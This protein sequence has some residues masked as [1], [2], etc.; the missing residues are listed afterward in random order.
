MGLKNKFQGVIHRLPMVLDLVL[1]STD[2]A[3]DSASKI[4]DLVGDKFKGYVEKLTGEL[5]A[6]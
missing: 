3:S 5:R 1:T 6:H 4:K 2:I